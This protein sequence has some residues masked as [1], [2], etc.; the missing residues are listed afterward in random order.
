MY[1]EFQ[2]SRKREFLKDEWIAVLIGGGSVIV[3]II[4]GMLSIIFGWN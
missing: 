2:K 4:L 3:P 1:T